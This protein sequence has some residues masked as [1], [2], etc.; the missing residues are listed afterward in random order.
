VFNQHARSGIPISYFT[1]G[2][3]VPEDIEPAAAKRLIGAIFS[4]R[5]ESNTEN[6]NVTGDR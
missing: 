5:R 1:T 6:N 4:K 2:Q 3:R